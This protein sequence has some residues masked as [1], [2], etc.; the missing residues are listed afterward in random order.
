V[1]RFRFFGFIA[2]S[3]AI[4]LVAAGF[5]Y[6]KV[7]ARTG[8]TAVLGVSVAEQ[9]GAPNLAED[10]V[11]C[12][13]ESV[14]CATGEFWD[15][16][17]DYLIP[18]RGVP[19]DLMQTYVSA[20]AAVASV[21]GYGWNYSYGMSLTP[22][23]AAGDVTVRQE[24]G[25]T[26]T[27]TENAR[28]AFSA[29]PWVMATL[30][31]NHAG[32]F[33][34][35]RDSQQVNYVFS[36]AGRLIAERDLDGET[37]SLQYA[38]SQ[39]RWITDAAHR[40]LTLSY[41]D[42]RVT[43]ITG[44]MGATTHLAYTAGN[45]TRLVDPA[46]RTWR[47]GYGRGHLLTSVT[48][49]R[50]LVTRI[51]Y[52]P[53]GRVS[54]VHGPGAADTT[55]RYFGYSATPSGG[56]TTV[57]GPGTTVTT[58]RYS[59]LLL[60]SET[61]GGGAAGV[62]TR[63]TYNRQT[64]PVSV[65]DPD[66]DV[67]SYTYNE[68]GDLL[69]STDPLNRTTRYTYNAFGEVT[70]Q[71][72]P[73]GA[74]SRSWYDAR[75]DLVKT[76]DADGNVT[77]YVPDPADPAQPARVSAPGGTVTAFTYDAFGDQVSMTTSPRP[78]VTDVTRSAYDAHGDLTCAASPDATARHI[79]CPASP[80]T[81]PAQS[82]HVSG[83]TSYTLDCDGE[84]MSVTD[85]AGDVTRDTYDGDG[86]VATVTD[87]AGNVTRYQY[88]AAGQPTTVTVN[89]T[90]ASA[91]TYDPAGDVLTQSDS[92]GQVTQYQYNSLDRVTTMTDP[93]GNITHYYYDP[94]GN[95]IR[96]V[97]P[98][99]QP[100]YYSYDAA[101]ELIAEGY[102]TAG[103]PA[104]TF[105]YSPNGEQSQIS[106]PAGTTTYTHDGDRRMLTTT[107]TTPADVR[108]TYSYAYSDATGTV[109]LTYPNGHIVTSHYNQAGELAKVTDWLGNTITFGYDPSGNLT[110]ESLPGGVTVSYGGAAITVTRHQTTL[111]GFAYARNKDG[112][113]SKS[114]T[115]GVP[116]SSQRIASYAYTPRGELTSDGNLSYT[117]DA[118]GNLATSSSGFAQT[119]NPADELS[120]RTIYGITTNFSY[121]PDGNLTS[122]S[123]AGGPTATL[124]YDQANWLTGYDSVGPSGSYAYQPDGLLTTA[125]ETSA[126]G[127]TT[128]TGF[129]WDQA[130]S[131]PV[132]LAT[133]SQPVPA[134]A[135]PGASP[136]AAGSA[137]TGSPAPESS[138]PESSAAASSA[139]G[140]PTPTSSVTGAPARGSPTTG[141]TAPGSSATGSPTTGSP[142]QGSS[143]ASSPAPGP[144]T[145]TLATPSY[146]S[147]PASS[148]TS[149]VYGPAGQPVEQITGS[150]PVF[151]IA[152]Q[153]GSIRLLVNA[154]GQEV[155][156]I[157]Y[158]PYGNVTGRT[159]PATTAL[160]YDGQYTDPATGYIYLR[161]R[162][163]DPQTGQ[164]ITRDPDAA[165]TGEP[166]SYAGDDPVNASDP[167]GLSWW[168]PFTWSVR[169]WI[170]IGI[171]AALGVGALFT[172]GADLTLAPEAFGA[173]AAADVTAGTI[174]EGGL[175]T[176]GDDEAL[177]SVFRFHDAS[178]P[179]TLQSRLASAEPDVQ[180]K[181]AS[182]LKSPT[183][184]DRLAE[185]H[186]Q[187]FVENSPFVS[188]T[189]NPAAAAATTDPWL[190]MI[191]AR[192]P[193]LSEFRVP[194]SLLIAPS[195]QLS[196][197]EGEYLFQG[198]DLINYL[199]ATRANPF[200]G[201]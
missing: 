48:D 138:A 94:A 142:A 179:T 162:Y 108:S 56:T 155:G 178:D 121:D 15:Q 32:Q 58:Y 74:V 122:T 161:A 35:T 147:P 3:V 105:S 73:S 164:F 101:G 33:I 97:A 82:A 166:Y 44:P 199:V 18:G 86:N 114:A 193:N 95:L 11:A 81:C 76:M 72:L 96:T 128:Q 143:A 195:N 78:G 10:Q 135:T 126:T 176:A 188:V 119:Y 69:T 6:V 102:T 113:I 70:S 67:T 111:A 120:T 39:L 63:Y 157:S 132:L 167:T 127:N 66:G 106:G 28:G 85:P 129:T 77:S 184:V 34:F 115:E 173:D 197:S 118:A 37:T 90:V 159:G 13:S 23:D 125:T 88:D 172:D 43:T 27:F 87:P 153:Q 146:S 137:A 141:S 145:A 117:Y 183:E 46:G 50:G 139:Q 19:L 62:T 17:T 174:A 200:G 42:G 191:V 103:A 41:Q 9:G 65:T 163:Y 79:T 140:S 123:N 83:V 198:D 149:Y 2:I 47:F 75:G 165:L 186:M 160:G 26:V 61:L 182:Q 80:R 55:W 22:P 116:G 148:Y 130:Q 64:L 134:P 30:T 98:S 104:M 59:G 54:A 99:G 71:T 53:S 93:L 131:T 60:R 51:G 187:G 156:A 29:P 180:A 194:A 92:P 31:R 107:Q 169:T 171:G 151:L 1:A 52:W 5:V 49:P 4:V 201:G 158:D 7:I 24:D 12:S 45:L 25:A 84:T 36:P 16:L 91:E 38:G 112:L 170:N 196:I 152:D 8:S 89:G 177:V 175:E 133:T 154:A 181:V 168:N 21:F 190:R 57:T 189:D 109:T 40:R 192:A 68:A 124:T 150:T 14:N 110:S 144:P 20:D 100:T 185:A 136:S